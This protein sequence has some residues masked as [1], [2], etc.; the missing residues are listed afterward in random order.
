MEG[1]YS[2]CRRQSAYEGKGY[3]RHCI[4]IIQVF[5]IERTFLA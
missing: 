5:V 2:S 1:T 4:Y 3:Q